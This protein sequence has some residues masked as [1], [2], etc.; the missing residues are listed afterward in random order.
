M[1]WPDWKKH[2]VYWVDS[3]KL[4]A[5]CP[6]K[7]AW[8]IH[9]FSVFWVPFIYLYCGYD[10][11]EWKVC[12]PYFVLRKSTTEFSSCHEYYCLTVCPERGFYWDPLVCFVPCCFYSKNPSVPPAAVHISHMHAQ[13]FTYTPGL[14]PPPPLHTT[15]SR[16][17]IGGRSI[18]KGYKLV[19]VSMVAGQTLLPWKHNI[20]GGITA[21]KYR[22]LHGSTT[23]AD[24][25]GGIR[26]TPTEH[27]MIKYAAQKSN[28]L[29]PTQCQQIAAFSLAWPIGK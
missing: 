17:E 1:L 14:N 2:F 18:W 23:S 20:E 16:G 29:H 12:S 13:R 9:T 3:L 24:R 7:V 25:V 28:A 19:L 10:V 5:S 21:G 11:G 6:V 15:L 22:F 4:P 27:W 8:I 26:S